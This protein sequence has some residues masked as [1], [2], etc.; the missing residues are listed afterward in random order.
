MHERWNLKE[1]LEPRI[2][3]MK[4][5]FLTAQ[6]CDK[7]TTSIFLGA[8]KTNSCGSSEIRK[9]DESVREVID[10]VFKH[11][12]QDSRNQSHGILIIILQKLPLLAKHKGRNKG[13]LHRDPKNPNSAL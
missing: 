5:E 12:S 8:W 6:A 10:V 1:L 7:H 9:L 4:P 3:I 11:D 13:R 2:D